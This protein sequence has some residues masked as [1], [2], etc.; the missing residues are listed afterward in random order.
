MLSM[1]MMG[2]VRD[3]NMRNMECVMMQCGRASWIMTRTR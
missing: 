1:A 3:M 2:V